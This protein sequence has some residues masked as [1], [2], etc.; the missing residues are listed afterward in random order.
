MSLCDDERD[1]MMDACGKPNRK[2]EEG[3][4]LALANP[5]NH[6][7]YYDSTSYMLQLSTNFHFYCMFMCSVGLNQAKVQ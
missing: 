1:M 2:R 5:S 6:P 4:T 3:R 7:R